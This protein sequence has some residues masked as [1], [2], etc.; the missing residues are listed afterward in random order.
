MSELP[1]TSLPVRQTVRRPY[2]CPPPS[3]RK[4]RPETGKN[5]QQR[6]I[7]SS[8][9][10]LHHPRTLLQKPLR[11]GND[12]PP[13]PRVSAVTAPAREDCPCLYDSIRKTAHACTT[14]S[15]SLAE[16]DR[17]ATGHYGK[18]FDNSPPSGLPADAR[19]RQPGAMFPT[20]GN[21]S[22]SGRESCSQ[23]SGTTVPCP[24]AGGGSAPHRKAPCS[25][26]NVFTGR[27][28]CPLA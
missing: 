6:K 4:T 2:S 21:R 26:S 12:R 5:T 9:F 19:P 7:P 11:D 1:G 20:V 3:C 24:L 18:V 16:R 22:T 25:L 8:F 10:Y 27:K 14:A 28:Q 13:Y 23:R 17:R 15:G